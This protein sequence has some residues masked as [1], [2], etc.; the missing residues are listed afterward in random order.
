MHNQLTLPRA[1][2]YERLLKAHGKN[3]HGEQLISNPTTPKRSH[4]ASYKAES[5]EN[6]EENAEGGS[7]AKKPRKTKAG[8]GKKTA[9]ST[10]IKTEEEE[11]E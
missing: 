4:A 9:Q 5:E 11:T 6:G 7:P 1:K 10:S 3:A 8:S 2:R